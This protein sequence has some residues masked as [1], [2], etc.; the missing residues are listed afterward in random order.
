MKLRLSHVHRSI[1]R[2]NNIEIN[3]FAIITGLNGTG[4]THLLHAIEEGAIQIEGIPS[5]EIV[6]YNYNDFNIDYDRQLNTTTG[7]KAPPKR[8]ES[9]NGYSIIE[10]ISNERTEIINSVDFLQSGAFGWLVDFVY[11]KGYEMSFLDLNQDE[12]RILG[13]LLLLDPLSSIY[14]KTLHSLPEKLRIIHEAYSTSKFNLDLITNKFEENIVKYFNQLMIKG[15][16]YDRSFLKWSI[17]DEGKYNEL[18]Y[19]NPLFDMWEHQRAFSSNFFGFLSVY[20]EKMRQ[21]EGYISQD[22]KTTRDILIEN[23]KQLEIILEEKLNPENLKLIKSFTTDKDIFSPLMADSGALDLTQIANEEKQYQIDKNRNDYNGYLKKNKGADVTYLSDQEFIEVYGNS[24]ISLLNEALNKYDCNGYEFRSTEVPNEYGFDALQYS[25]D[26]N[27]FH[28]DKQY[29]TDL[30]SVSSGERT[31]LAL[32]FY[33]YKLKYKRKMVASLLLLDEIDSSL[34]PSMSKRLINVLYELFYN[35]LKIK[36]IISTHSPSTVA[37]APDNSLYVMKREG[38]DRLYPSS[39]DSALEELTFGV[40]S[41]SINYENRRQVFVESKY[42]VSYYEKLYQIFKKKLNPEV[43]LNF[44]ASGDIQ[45]DKNGLPKS[46]CEQVIEIT[47]L[48]RNSGNKFIWGIIDWD[49]RTKELGCSYVRVLGKGERY[50]IE[51]FILDPLLMAILL[52]S[53]KIKKPEF[54]GLHEDFKVYEILNQ[55]EASLQIII[56]RLLKELNFQLKIDLD[57]LVDY[58]TID[59]RVLALPKGFVEVQGHELEEKYLKAF[60]ELKKLKKNDEKALKMEVLNKVVEEYPS[61]SPMGLL[62]I[63][64]D[65]QKI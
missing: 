40:P 44:I 21:L 14:W 60:P 35:E 2:L 31:L 34:H 46:N 19:Q 43:S 24:P 39:K 22:L 65:V 12:R 63:L 48:L 15:L 17:T 64:Q 51:N 10:R 37:F 38:D 16:G 9:K 54:F 41:F 32:T 42:D 28:K 27:L 30:D 61:L 47:K 26:I 3:D 53:E 20:R 18:N 50:S 49:M 25:I 33:I 1:E 7:E 29:P 6:Y 5:S 8:H 36:I 55:N 11:N 4:K 58:S 52:M 59:G 23:F 62:V 13:D 57:D 45:K 56:D